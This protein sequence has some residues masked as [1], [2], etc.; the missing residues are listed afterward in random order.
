MID[1][2][3]G[4]RDLFVPRPR[5]V[6]R[7][8]VSDAYGI[9]EGYITPQ[10]FLVPEIPSPE[11]CIRMFKGTVIHDIVEKVLKEEG[12]QTE[13]SCERDFGDFLLVGRVDAVKDGTLLELKTNDVELATAKPGQAYQ[14]RMYLS[15][16][17]IEEG[18]V[19]Q[20]IIKG[21]QIIIKQLRKSKRN[22]EWFMKQIELLDR[23]HSLLPKP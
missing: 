2:T 22:D 3:N 16:L 4:V 1:I 10:N 15:L 18:I 20:P 13:V 9:V 11:A 19:G 5:K 12:W 6:G 17:E 21:D 23:F 8:R 14:M 7:I